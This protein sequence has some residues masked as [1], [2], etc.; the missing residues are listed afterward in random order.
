M[1]EELVNGPFGIDAARWGTGHSSR[2]VLVVV[3]SVTAGTRLA[4]VTPLLESDLRIQ[5]V[6]TEG[7]S[8][9]PGGTREFLRELGGIVVPWRQATHERFDLAVAASYG[10][11]EQ[12][13]APVLTLS[14]GAGYG[15]YPNRWDGYG[16]PAARAA[17]GLERQQLVYHGRVVP[18]AIAL[19]HHDGIAQLARACPEAVPTAFVAGDP[20]YD[21]LAA[22]V[23]MRAEFRRALGVED[24]RKLVVVSSTWGPHSLLGRHRDVI[25]RLV[26]ELPRDEYRVVAILHPNIWYWYGAWQIQAW[27]ADALRNGLGLV[28]PEEGWRAA[29]AAADVVLGDHGSVTYY[30]ASIGVPVL[31][32]AFPE[33]DID[34]ESPV[35]ALGEIAPRMRLDRPLL[36]QL[37]AAPN[38]Y[39]PDHYATFSS[40][41]SSVPGQSARLIRREMYRLMRLPE[42]ASAPP[43][44]TVPAPRL[45][46][47]IST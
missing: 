29:L 24:G 7:S 37:A 16:P 41:V 27:Y 14:H 10:R 45:L 8:S 47:H 22:S 12:I 25:P 21:R 17:W 28:P 33:E 4:D 5:V 19:S 6:F 34:P 31:L 20:C 40:Q 39:S 9:F 1:Y 36:P 42:P 11:L 43:T 32:A 23:P 18:A 3:H 35:T 2:T 38:A 46:T 44:R 26:A 15:K 30:A 13:H